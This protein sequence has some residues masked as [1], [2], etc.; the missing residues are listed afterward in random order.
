[1]QHHPLERLAL[2]LA[3]VRPAP[4]GALH[5]ARRVQL[6]LHPGVAPQ[7][8]VIAHQILVEMLHVPTPVQTPVQ[9]QHQF[10]S[11]RR[12]P[13]G[14]R[15]ANPLVDQTGEPVLLVAIPIA[16]ELALRHPQQFACL[17]H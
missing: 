2:A 5:Q 6:R 10:G 14:R 3:A 7:E 16:P 1:M 17:H 13:L 11:R 4:L 15:L 9:L 8:A 12:N